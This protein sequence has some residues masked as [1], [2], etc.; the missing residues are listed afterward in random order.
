VITQRFLA[1]AVAA[2]VLL[3]AAGALAASATPSSPT[4]GAAF[5]K[6]RCHFVKKKVH[7]K[8]KRVRV[9][10]TAKQG[11]SQQ[12]V[13]KTLV[14]KVV[15]AR[16]PA[17]RYNAV[18]AVLR[19]LHLGVVTPAGKPIVVSPEP[20]AARLFQ[21]YDFEARG[22]AQQFARRQTTTLDDLAVALKKGGLGL[23]AK[24][25]LPAALLA[26]G[27]RDATRRAMAKPRS[28]RSLLPLVVRELGLRR[29]F[30]TSKNLAPAKVQLDSLQAWLVIADMSLPVLRQ[31]PLPKSRVLSA[32]A[33][34]P[35]LCEK[36]NDAVEALQDRIEKALGGKIQKWISDEAVGMIYD[37]VADKLGRQATR[38]AIKNA[39]RWAVRG[40]YNVGRAASVAGPLIDLVHG[41]LLAYSIDVRSLEASLPPIHWWHAAGEGTT[42]TFRVKVTMLDDYGD[43]LVKCGGLV[44]LDLPPKGGVKDVWVN[45]EQAQGDLKSQ[46]KLRCVS[47][48]VVGVCA[49]KTGADGIAT[50]V[51]TPKTEALPGRG[52]QVEVTGVVDG[53]ALYQTASGGGITGGI[54]QF[55]T[56]KF[57][58]TRWLVRSHEQYI[59]DLSARGTQTTTWTERRRDVWSTPCGINV[60]GSG[61]Q[62]IRFGTATP[63]RVVFYRDA[64]GAWTVGAAQNPYSAPIPLDSTIDR[65]GTLD[66]RDATPEWPCAGKTA[67]RPQPAQAAASDCGQRSYALV[68]GLTYAN[69]QLVLGDATQGNPDPFANCPVVSP[70]A[71]QLLDTGAGLD[72]ARLP[73]SEPIELAGSRTKPYEVHST[74]TF[75][76][77]TSTTD[78][79][80][81]TTIDWTMTLRP[82]LNDSELSII[83]GGRALR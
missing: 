3:T 24:R 34:L 14:T 9:C 48:P 15:Q 19:A 71:L 73:G 8:V 64:T 46:G 6:K 39:P 35:R 33:D 1:A 41:A 72:S 77:G 30:D 55:L 17:A 18:L 36:Y 80:E 25:P 50:L 44:G 75:S 22:L 68:A 56:P 81:S 66:S 43:V 63:V 70:Y 51:F 57:G 12:I 79:T 23:D 69:G 45:W 16:T 7:G 10:T 82:D 20:N 58:S 4:I 53:I 27:L 61:N 78:I 42:L 21:L 54:A 76:H 13:A 49:T 59:F 37:K 74:Y 32:G 62:T 83:D 28:A 67:W 65:Q 47:V 29:G 26:E 52:A 2:F 60:D 40:L 31:V 11:P 38:W 5:A